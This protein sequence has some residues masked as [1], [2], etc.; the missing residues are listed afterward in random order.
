MYC[1]SCGKDLPEDAEYCPGCG[2][3]QAFG[4][5]ELASWGE[6]FLAYVIDGILVGIVSSMFMWPMHLVRIPFMNIGVT[7]ILLFL[8]WGYLEGT[9]GQSLG[10]R[11][12][13]IRVTDV[14][15]EP[16]DISR[17]LYQAFGK[18]FLM[19][20]DVIAGWILFP[21]KQQRLFNNLSNTIVVKE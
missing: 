7:N 21:D 9:N 5:L 20:L 4:E 13:N 6:R 12:M 10:K 15:G 2:A 8:Y 18:A 3:R 16:I 19:P 1:K 17:S 14:Y 11:A